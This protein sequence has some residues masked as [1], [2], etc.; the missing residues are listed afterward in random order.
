MAVK[1][2]VSKVTPTVDEKKLYFFE[3]KS[4]RGLI[5]IGISANP[6]HDLPRL[7]QRYELS[8]KWK[9]TFETSVFRGSVAQLILKELS[10]KLE[11]KAIS[12]DRH[13]YTI[14]KSLLQRKISEVRNSIVDNLL[15]SGTNRSRKDLNKNLNEAKI[16]RNKLNKEATALRTEIRNLNNQKIELKTKKTKL[17]KSLE[18]TRKKRKTIQAS[19]DTLSEREG[20]YRSHSARVSEIKDDIQRLNKKHRDQLIAH[21]KKHRDQLIAHKKEEATRA[22]H[23]KRLESAI[24]NKQKKILRYNKVLEAANFQISSSL[25][26]KMLLEMSSAA[27]NIQNEKKTKNSPS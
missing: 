10:K 2:K 22:N 20:L 3:S 27:K 5:G 4:H 14:T 7:L 13:I 1:K 19:I 21:K 18:E 15:L 11:A 16:K 26:E 25:W 9:I 24:R 17:E 6:E 8:P 23:V 12:R